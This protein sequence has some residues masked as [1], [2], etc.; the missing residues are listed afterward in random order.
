MR[1]TAALMCAGLLAACAHNQP[2]A[3]RLRPATAEGWAAVDTGDPAGTRRRA[4]AEAQRAA[5]ETAAGVK[6]SARTSVSQAVAVEQKI[7]S[8]ARGVIRSYEVLGEKEEGGFHKTR[9]RAL[10]EIDPP[11]DASAPPEP[12]FGDPTVAVSLSG[13]Y[14]R[15][16]AAGVRRGLLDRGFTVIDTETSDLIVSGEVTVRP[17]AGVDE[18]SSCRARV[19][20]SARRR[21]TGELLWQESRESSALDPALAAAEAKA[22]ESAGRLGGSA[23]AREVAAR[24]SD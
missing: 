24:L 13:E 3:V 6:V 1:L 8:R 18:W 19:T 11:L 12:P 7:T 5:V 4:L 9:I 14:S 16:A 23:L 21:K 22:S 10:V 2:R 20:L 15:S 17:I